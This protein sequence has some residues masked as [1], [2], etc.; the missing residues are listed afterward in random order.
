MK[1]SLLLAV[2][3]VLFLTTLANAQEEK[4]LVKTI[5]SVGVM[6]TVGGLTEFSHPQIHGEYGIAPSINLI[7]R[8]TRHKV[9]Y[10][11][12]HNAFQTMHG[13]N[14]PKH[15]DAYVFYQKNFNKT[16]HKYSVGIEKL[17]EMH[18]TELAIFA[19]LGSHTIFKHQSNFVAIGVTILPQWFVMKK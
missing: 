8:A 15:F 13:V 2:I 5:L 11:T 4:H 10:E 7:T 16:E 17:V 1:K 6:G 19:E 12:L 18:T 9:M 14:L 3:T